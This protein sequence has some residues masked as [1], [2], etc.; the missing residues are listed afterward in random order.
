[1]NYLD[2]ETIVSLDVN[3]SNGSGGNSASIKTVLKA[4]DLSDDESDLGTL[5][6]SRC[7]STSFSNEKIQTLMSNFIEVESTRSKDANGIYISRKYQ[8]ITSLKLKSHCFIVRG[9]DSHP[10]D[11][12]F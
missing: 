5:I 1:M 11:L 2:K 3:F 7:R 10:K 4:K 8:D 9:K 6:G 12:G